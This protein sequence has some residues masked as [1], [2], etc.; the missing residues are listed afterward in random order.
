MITAEEG[1]GWGLML[2]PFLAVAFTVWLVKH[3]FL[4]FMWMFKKIKK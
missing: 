2:F 4:F 3:S 1:V